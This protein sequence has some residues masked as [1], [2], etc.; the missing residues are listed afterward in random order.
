MVNDNQIKFGGQ[1]VNRHVAEF[2]EGPFFPA[3]ANAGMR[4]LVALRGGNQGRKCAAVVPRNAGQ[5][6]GGPRVL[7]RPNGCLR[8]KC[9]LRHF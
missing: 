2:V 7:W 5:L 8:V 1:L 6:D 4:F 3:D 9:F